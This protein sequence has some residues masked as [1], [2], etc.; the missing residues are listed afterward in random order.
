M[1]VAQFSNA[2]KGL[3]FDGNHS[4]FLGSNG[5]KLILTKFNEENVLLQLTILYKK[6]MYE[7][8][9]ILWKAR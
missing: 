7:Q 8:E 9:G 4:S 3:H 1:N 6:L 2:I 5:R